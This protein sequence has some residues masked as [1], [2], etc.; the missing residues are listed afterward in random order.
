M[1]IYLITGVAGFL[2]SRLANDLLSAGHKVIG[3]G[4]SEKLERLTEI[5]LNENFTYLKG[6][7]SVQ[8]L[9]QLEGITFSGIFHLA[10]QQPSS[11]QVDYQTYYQSN[12][13][14]TRILIEF[15]KHRTLDFFIYASTVS[16]FGKKR[17][18]VIDENS[19]PEPTNY[20]S[21]TKYMSENILRIES[22]KLKCKVI[23]IRFQSIFGK[24]DGYGIVHTFYTKLKKN[25]DVELFSKGMISRNL[26]HID[27]AVQI[28][29]KCAEKYSTMEN[30]ELF[31]AASIKSVKTYD[32]ASL[33]KKIILSNSNII[34]SD[35]KYI[36]DW[37]VFVN[38][39]KAKA[40]LDF[41]PASMEDRICQY[42]KQSE[43]VI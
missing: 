6:S 32:I 26:I 40:K 43:D 5:L 7:I 24:D 18:N 41:L 35:K 15:F 12:V 29:L 3:I 34:C 28:M 37:D 1:K 25:E 16:V 23:V 11:S 39:S 4:R 8:L 10:S 19:I 20:Y 2:G 38:I 36:F 33:I 22:E 9:S 27:D 42:I 17:D 21:L 31:N 13:E 14:T 30:F